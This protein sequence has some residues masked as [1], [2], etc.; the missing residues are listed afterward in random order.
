MEEKNRTIIGCIAFLL[1]IL[2]IGIGG[3]LYTFKNDKHKETIKKENKITDEYKKDKNK[4]YIYYTDEKVISEELNLIYKNPIINLNNSQTNAIY[5]E[6]SEENET[7]YNNIQKIS[8]TENPTGEEIAFNTDD[9]FSATIRDY[10]NYEYKNYITLVVTD[11]SYDC[12]KGIHDYTSIKS[13]LFDV[14]KN[15]R[16]SN[17]DVLELYNT[18]LSEIKEKIKIELQENQEIIDGIENIKIDETIENLSNNNSYG[19]YID[20]SGN[21]IIKYIVKSNQM[22]YNEVMIIG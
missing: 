18:S 22:N 7:Y 15:E 4:D 21:L 11:S 16:I 14:S 8:E 5:N 13:Y 20:N 10:E 12:F 17:I 1:L 6:L 9:I 3:Y 2:V 19:L